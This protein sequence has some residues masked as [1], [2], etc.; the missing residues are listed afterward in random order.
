MSRKLMLLVISCALMAS[1]AFIT[2]DKF[3]KAPD[4]KPDVFENKGTVF[5]AP[6][7]TYSDALNSITEN[8]LKD[9][10]QYLA[11]DELEGRMSGKLGNVKAFLYVEEK[12]KSYGLQVMK[13][14]FSIRRLNPGPKNEM[15]NNFTHNVYAWIEGNDPKLKNEILVIGAHGDHIGYGPSMSRTPNRREV[16]HGADDNASGTSALLEIAEAFSLVKDKVKRTVV[17]Q[18][19]SAEEMGLIGS[20]YYC[21]NPTFPLNNPN[22]KNHIAMINMDM[23]GYLNKGSYPVAWS[24]GSSSIDMSKY[25]SELNN[26]YP[27]AN[28]ITSRGSG[29]SDHAPF[30]NKRIPVAFLHTGSHPYY[31]TP[32]DTAD[33]INYKGMELVAKYAFELAYKISQNNN[34]PQFN[35]AIFEPMPY[36]HDHGHGV[37]FLNR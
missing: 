15:G 1:I 10:L 2:K 31:H 22:I 27:F 17:F 14:Q 24:S 35:V 25:I 37:K 11:S 4:I 5:E 32:D 23:I 9:H 30:Y 18:C 7:S 26:T 3:A 16:H 21:D 19:Y 29:G 28:T 34:P 20:R 8:Q 12:F 36:I 6:V 33:K 13:H